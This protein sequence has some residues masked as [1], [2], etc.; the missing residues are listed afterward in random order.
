MVSIQQCRER[1]QLKVREEINGS[2]SSRHSSF[3]KMVSKR[4]EGKCIVKHLVD[5]RIPMKASSDS[6]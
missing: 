4:K 3:G 5:P 1:R 2:V 6:R